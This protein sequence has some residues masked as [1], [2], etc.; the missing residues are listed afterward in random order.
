MSWTSETSWPD[1]R[2]SRREPDDRA[3]VAGPHEDRAV[4]LGQQREDLPVVQLGERR[5]LVAAVADLEELALGPGAD[6]EPVVDPGQGVDE[7]LDPQDL[8]RHSVGV[9]PIDGVVARR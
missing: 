6:Q 7:R 9:E 3:G 2:V 5:G 8:A 1:G 4:G